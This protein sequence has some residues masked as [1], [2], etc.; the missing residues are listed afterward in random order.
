MTNEYLTAP[1]DSESERRLN[2]ERLRLGLV[3]TSDRE[4]FTEWIQVEARGFHSATPTPE[5]LT[6][7]LNGLADRRTTGVWD[8]SA[9]EP[10]APV[11]TVSSWPVDLTVPGERAVPASAAPSPYSPFQRRPSTRA[12]ASPPPR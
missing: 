4:A 5:S 8:D 10:Q 11:A 2:E 3:D 7:Q 9:A 6:A 1:I 12:T